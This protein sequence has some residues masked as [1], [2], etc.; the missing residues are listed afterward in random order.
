MDSVKVGAISIG[1]RFRKDMGDLDALAASIKAH[2]LLQH[3]GIT[4]DNKLVFGE[5]R[6]R[7]CRDILKWKEIPARVV[8]VASLL[9]AERDENEVRKEFTVSERVAIG[10]AIEE[11]MAERRGASNPVNV[12]ELKGRETRDV[13]AEKAGFGSEASYRQAKKVSEKGAPELVDAVDQGK[14]SISAAAKVAE[15]PKSQ[16]KRLVAQGAV[17]EKAA[18][19]R[20]SKKPEKPGELERLTEENKELRRDL[21]ELAKQQEPLQDEV[22][23]LRKIENEGDKLKAACA[24]VKRLQSVVRGQEERIRGLMNEVAD[25]KQHSKKWQRMYEKAVKDA[26]K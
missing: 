7:A 10:K 18:E 5:R 12:P 3:I 1:Q 4:K 13:A 23:F 22:E 14:V 16:Q 26:Q 19:I 9:E 6:L 2:G 21:T 11:E 15:L 24:E 25:Y 17:A 20:Q 8:D